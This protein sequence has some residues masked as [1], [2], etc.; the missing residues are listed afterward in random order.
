MYKRQVYVPFV[1]GLWFNTFNAFLISKSLLI[2]FNSIVS[3]CNVASIIIL[4]LLLL[5]VSIYNIF[6]VILPLVVILPLIPISLSSASLALIL[7]RVV[8]TKVSIL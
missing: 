2:A 1:V 4:L 3:Q 7:P 5:I 6:P 8:S